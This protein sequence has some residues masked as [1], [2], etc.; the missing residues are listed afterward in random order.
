MQEKNPQDEVEGFMTKREHSIK[1][2]VEQMR[3]VVTVRYQFKY[4]HKSKLK[5]VFGNF[6]V[7]V[8]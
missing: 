3:P 2:L 7:S 1:K 8:M 5:T 4:E 6:A